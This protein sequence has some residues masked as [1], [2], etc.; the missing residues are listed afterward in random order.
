[1]M[2]V[3][4]SVAPPHLGGVSGGITPF[5]GG[6]RGAWGMSLGGQAQTKLVV[7]GHP[8]RALC[9]ALVSFAASFVG[10][11]ALRR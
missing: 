8:G 2:H 3:G 6:V 5:F 10:R 1:M 4:K 7:R 11:A 9:P